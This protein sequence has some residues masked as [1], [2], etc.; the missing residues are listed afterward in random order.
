VTTPFLVACS[1]LDKLLGPVAS[2]SWGALPSL[3]QEPD[4]RAGDERCVAA[5]ASLP[6][7]DSSWGWSDASCDLLMASMCRLIGGCLP[8]QHAVRGRL[9]AHCCK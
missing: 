2:F 5:N 1:W 3:A 7:P 6:L 8:W 4:N 9:A